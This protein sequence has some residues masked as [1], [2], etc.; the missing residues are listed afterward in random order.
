MAASDRILP[1]SILGSMT[2]KTIH[3]TYRNVIDF[4]QEN[5]FSSSGEWKNSAQSWFKLNAKGEPRWI[6]EVK[7]TRCYYSKNALRKMIAESG[8]SKEKWATWADEAAKERAY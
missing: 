7:F 3:W 1:R 4:L 6:V 2:T 5:D 8:L